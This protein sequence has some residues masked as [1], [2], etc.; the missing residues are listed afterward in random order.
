LRKKG[1]TKGNITV[2]ANARVAG[3]ETMPAEYDIRAY[4]WETDAVMRGLI[5]HCGTCDRIVIAECRSRKNRVSQ[6]DMG[7]V[8]TS[9]RCH[10]E[11]PIIP[12]AV[13]D[14][15]IGIP[16]DLTLESSRLQAGLISLTFSGKKQRVVVDR[17]G[18]GKAVVK[19]SSLDSYVRDVHYKKLRKLRLRFHSDEW[20][21]NLGFVMEGEQRRF[22]DWLPAVAD[23]IRS[24]RTGD[25][26]GGRVWFDEPMNRIYVIRAEGRECQRLADAVAASVRC[27]LPPVA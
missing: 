5:W 19:H 23:R 15:Q 6:R 10:N 7:R 11:G 14:L 24:W 27:Q 8:L 1:K 21:G 17:L 26:I 25:N 18:M 9:I 3:V 2:D 22:Y 20:Q 12:W 4:G 13:F 16:S